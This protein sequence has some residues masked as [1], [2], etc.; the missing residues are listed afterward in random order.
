MH[1]H[2]RAGF[3]DQLPPVHSS[4]KYAD[5]HLL[6]YQ[7]LSSAIHVEHRSIIAM[8]MVGCASFLLLFACLETKSLQNKS[9]LSALKVV[10]L[11]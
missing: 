6:H 5:E 7:P 11:S 8:D 3:L 9:L 1:D 10:R 4:V 2:S